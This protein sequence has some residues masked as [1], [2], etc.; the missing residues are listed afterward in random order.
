MY[1]GCFVLC[2]IEIEPTGGSQSWITLSE[3]ASLNEGRQT[4]RVYAAAGGWSINWINFEKDETSSLEDPLVSEIGNTLAV[5]PNPVTD[6]FT[7]QYNVAE[8]AP[9]EFNLY[10]MKGRLIKTERREIILSH[11][12]EF[13]WQIDN[14]LISGSYFLSMHQN[15]N[16][17]ATFRLLKS[18]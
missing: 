13:E 5:L 1:L 16:Q 4:L 2:S 18:E 9:I 14:K 6:F 7:V 10:D 3:I 12:G 11:A 17:L 8:F 15:G